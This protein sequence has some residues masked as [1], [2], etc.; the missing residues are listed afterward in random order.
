MFSS[1]HIDLSKIGYC[2][3]SSHQTQGD[4][5]ALMG[6]LETLLT[7][8]DAHVNAMMSQFAMTGVDEQYRGVE[9]VW[10]NSSDAVHQIINLLRSVLERNDQTAADT[11]AKCGNVV[12]G[13]AVAH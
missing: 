5:T 6:R 12:G 9:T 2:E 11:I 10:K 4:L 13:L 7:T 8:H 1:Y 3:A